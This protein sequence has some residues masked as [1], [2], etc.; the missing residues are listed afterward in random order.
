MTKVRTIQESNVDEDGSAVYRRTVKGA[1]A[2][3]CLEPAI[4][5]S[6]LYKQD[7]PIALLI[8][9]RERKFA[10]AC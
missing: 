8:F 1:T 4:A 5:D 9:P 7:G 3:N 6:L 10:C 2:N